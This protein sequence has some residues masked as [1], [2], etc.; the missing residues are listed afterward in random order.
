ML[1]LMDVGS[2]AKLWFHHHK[3][4]RLGAL[5]CS[6]VWRGKMFGQLR[7]RLNYE[8]I[9]VSNGLVQHHIYLLQ[10][11]VLLLP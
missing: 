1:K 9:T 8:D 7:L 5:G 3:R 10:V 2:T 4:L 11:Q 6:R